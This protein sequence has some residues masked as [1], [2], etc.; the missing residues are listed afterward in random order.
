MLNNYFNAELSEKSVHHETK[1]EM[2]KSIKIKQNN[3]FEEESWNS[4]ESPVHNEDRSLRNFNRSEIEWSKNESSVSQSFQNRR[5]H[6]EESSSVESETSRE[7]NK[8]ID[9]PQ[10]IDIKPHQ[11]ELWEHSLLN[12]PDSIFEL[13]FVGFTH[14]ERVSL[15]NWL[16]LYKDR[17]SQISKGKA[18]LFII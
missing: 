16:F 18:I 5:F 15:W 9:F 10:L 6:L 4:S 2:R 17:Q 3:F 1:I 7:N 14:F 12:S 11:I 13:W 8:L